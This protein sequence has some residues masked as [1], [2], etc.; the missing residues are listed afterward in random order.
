MCNI[1][2]RS[3]GVDAAA[4]DCSAEGRE[5]LEKMVVSQN[6]AQ[7]EK[8]FLMTVVGALTAIETNSISFEDVEFILFSVGTV[9]HLSESSCNSKIEILVQKCMELEDIFELTPTGFISAINEL[10][11]EAL[12][13]LREV[14]PL[15]FE[16]ERLIS[17]LL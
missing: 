1:I 6:K 11:N 13:I 8:F 15:D 9:E 12:T 7:F 4:Y 5:F 10:K 16:K 3:Q 14:G 2:Q 17:K